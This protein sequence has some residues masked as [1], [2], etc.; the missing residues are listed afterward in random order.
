MNAMRSPS[1]PLKIMGACQAMWRKDK[2][3]PRV[4]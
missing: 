3:A 1:T 4:E 2:S